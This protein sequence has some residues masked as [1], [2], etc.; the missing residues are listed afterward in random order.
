MTSRTSTCSWSRSSGCRTRCSSG[1]SFGGWVAAEICVRDTS[2]FGA[3]VLL[4]PVGIKVG[5]RE[6][7]DIADVF[8]L[9]Q[10]EMTALAYHDPAKRVRDYSTMSDDERLAI[11]RSR[12]AYTYFGWR[13]YMHNPGLR[14]WLRRIDLPTVVVWGAS[15]G[16][17]TPAYGRAF[18]AEI[19][20]ARFI[21]IPGAGH[22]PHIERPAATVEV[23]TSFAAPEPAATEPAALAR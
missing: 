14:R 6:T 23:I 22:Y 10:D 4:D 12:E 19:P 16:I 9:S 21:E 2:A 11:A 3:L 18:G 1:A 5:D 20:R 17:V 15:D 13:P 7:R 8:A